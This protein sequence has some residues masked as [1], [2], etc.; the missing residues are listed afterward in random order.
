M[1]TYKP[2]EIQQGQVQAPAPELNSKYQYGLSDEGIERSS[3]KKDFVSSVA[4]RLQ[5]R[6]NSAKKHPESTG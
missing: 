2:H 1:D 5:V 3:T 6:H 4:K